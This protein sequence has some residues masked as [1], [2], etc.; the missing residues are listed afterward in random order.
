MLGRKL[1][2]LVDDLMREGEAIPRVDAQAT[3]RQAILEITGK[4]LGVALGTL[5]V[6]ALRLMERHSITSLFVLDTARGEVVAGVLHIHDLV[7]AGLQ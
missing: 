2:L 1:T 7:K 6:D 5:A 3:M 4:G